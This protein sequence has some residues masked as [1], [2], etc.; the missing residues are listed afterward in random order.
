M[1]IPNQ[2]LSISSGRFIYNLPLHGIYFLNR[3]LLT[4]SE[5][6]NEG[7]SKTYVTPILVIFDPP[8]SVHPPVLHNES[9][10]YP[11]PRDLTLVSHRQSY[12]TCIKTYLNTCKHKEE[13]T[14]KQRLINKEKK[15]GLVRS[16]TM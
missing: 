6:R 5:K 11:L 10:S 3:P 15:R 1:P 4:F 2:C 7:P 9:W 12:Y 8:L 13:I 16:A 14:R